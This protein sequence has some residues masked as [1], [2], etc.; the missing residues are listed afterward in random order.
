[1][2]YKQIVQELRESKDLNVQIFLNDVDKITKLSQKEKKSL[3]TKLQNPGVIDTL[4]KNYIPTIIRIAYAN[5][6]SGGRRCYRC[7]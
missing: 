1:M 6:R 7:L 2:K 5:S 4:V 3:L